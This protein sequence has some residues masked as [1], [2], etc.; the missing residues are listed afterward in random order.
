M[1]EPQ[2]ET[3]GVCEGK[4]MAMAMGIIYAKGHDGPWAKEMTCLSCDGKGYFTPEQV[5][6]R[7]QGEQMRAYRLDMGLTF[8]DAAKLFGIRPSEVSAMESG[9][10]DNSNWRQLTWHGA[11]DAE[12]G[13]WRGD[14]IRVRKD[15]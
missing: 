12:G 1:T 9:K 15:Q 14:A 2:N 5:I 8:R 6:W 3:C 11:E 4:G 10:V 7:G 13:S